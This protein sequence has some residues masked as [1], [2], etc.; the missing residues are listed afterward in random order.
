[1]QGFISDL[2]SVEAD[3]HD[4][5]VMV[6]GDVAV[7][8][9]TCVCCNIINHSK[10]VQMKIILSDQTVIDIDKESL[11]I[12]F[13][14]DEERKTMANNLTGMPDKERVRVYAI[15]NPQYTEGRALVDN[16]LKLLGYEKGIDDFS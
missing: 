13:D 16:S 14:N 7:M 1:M 2:L 12:V 4:R 11:V 10:H 9:A 5:L 6:L 15:F 3:R 8:G